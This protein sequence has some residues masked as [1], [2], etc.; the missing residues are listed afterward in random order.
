MAQL[1]RGSAA[2]SE[3]WVQTVAPSVGGGSQTPTSENPTPLL[4]F[5]DT[6]THT[7]T[8]S[9]THISKYKI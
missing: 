3:D 6:L 2:L 8:H 4:S 9:H 5:V 7:Y 1:L